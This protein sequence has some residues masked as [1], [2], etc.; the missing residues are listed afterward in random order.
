MSS[1]TWGLFEK[2]IY[3]YWLLL[4]RVYQY[5]FTKLRQFWWS[6]HISHCAPILSKWLMKFLINREYQFIPVNIYNMVNVLKINLKDKIWRYMTHRWF[7][8]VYSE[9]SSL[10]DQ[11][12]LPVYTALLLV[13]NYQSLS[14]EYIWEIRS[15]T[16][17]TKYFY[18]VLFLTTRNYY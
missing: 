5:I 15:D 8:E 2:S 17:A 4:N 10:P 9:T 7:L 18:F 11:T 14:K 1:L 6:S 13:L 3:Q 16:Y 12:K